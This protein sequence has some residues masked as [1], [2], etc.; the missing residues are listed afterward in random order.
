MKGDNDENKEVNV[1][2]HLFHCDLPLLQK[3]ACQ[4]WNLD[5]FKYIQDNT[6]L[7]WDK[8]YN[9]IKKEEDQ[10][11]QTP[12]QSVDTPNVTTPPIIPPQQNVENEIKSEIVIS[13]DTIVESRQENQEAPITTISDPNVSLS[14]EIPKTNPELADVVAADTATNDIGIVNHTII[15][16]EKKGN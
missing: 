6:K 2:A 16:T 1:I 7:L 10:E 4:Y 9:K 14:D 11:Q 8:N 12:I 13:N 15:P 5:D 3:L